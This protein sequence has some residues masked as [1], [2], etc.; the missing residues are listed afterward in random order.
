[1]AVC[2]KCKRK[3]RLV[4]W[5]QNCPNCGVNL[6]YYGFEDRFYADAKYA[7][8]G[9]AK[10]RV[11][12]LKVKTALIGGKLQIARLV[13]TVLPILAA[14]FPAG[15]LIV[16][17]PLF[18]RD[19]SI[20]GQGFFK[21]LTDGTF[22]LL[23]SLKNALIIG[24][25][26]EKLLRAYYSVAVVLAASV[27]VL[28]CEI[29]CF[30]SI[31]KMSFIICAVSI[32]GVAGSVA[33]MLNFNSLAVVA[34][35]TGSLAV[36]QKGFGGFA[37]I[38][39]FFIIFI[40]NAIIAQK[41]LPIEYKEGDLYRIEVARRLKRGEITIDEI[42]HPIYETERERAEREKSAVGQPEAG[43]GEN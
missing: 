3:L 37:L 43:G 23:G 26:A 35:K 17:F 28:L 6:M 11:K 18:D 10:V 33:L 2:P 7:E 42:P 34:S 5:R 30:I 14:M 13:L 36:V 25:T 1:M 31:K 32:I 16:S 12:L 15:R 4:D 29:L 8:M 24:E 41:G 40:I 27:I 20:S 39:A 9:F 38:A 21:A 19:F 22:S